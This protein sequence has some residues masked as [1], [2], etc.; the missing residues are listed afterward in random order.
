M[1]GSDQTGPSYPQV[2]RQGEEWDGGKLG[3]RGA[4]APLWEGGWPRVQSQPYAGSRVDMTLQGACR[5]PEGAG[6][7]GR[8]PLSDSC[9]PTWVLPPNDLGKSLVS[10]PCGI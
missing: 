8:A 2:H 4:Q 6:G 7:V 3:G 5:H 9:A 10:M 1:T